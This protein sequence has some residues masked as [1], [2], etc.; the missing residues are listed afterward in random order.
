MRLIRARLGNDVF[1]A[2]VEGDEAV[3]LT[4][5]SSHPAGDVLREALAERVDLAGD[6]ARVPL[7]DVEVLA[8]LA[9]AER[10]GATGGPRS[11]SRRLGR[12]LNP[13]GKVQLGHCHL[14]GTPNPVHD[15]LADHR[16]TGPPAAGNPA[17]DTGQGPA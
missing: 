3:V 8:P 17:T 13:R 2:R 1:L 5:E 4:H 14:G 6:G 9:K 12:V 10:P 15:P 7:G 11:R 16:T